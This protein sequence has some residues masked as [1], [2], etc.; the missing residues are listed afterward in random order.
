[1]ALRWARLLTEAMTGP[2]TMGSVA[3]QVMPTGLGPWRPGCEVRTIL[4]CLGRA[5]AFSGLVGGTG[6]S[7]IWGQDIQVASG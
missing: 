4:G 2:R 3:P 6:F 7:D 1:M 5:A